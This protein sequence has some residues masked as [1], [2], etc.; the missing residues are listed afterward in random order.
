MADGDIFNIF[1]LHI[2][3]TCRSCAANWEFSLHATKWINIAISPR[4]DCNVWDNSTRITT[5]NRRRVGVDGEVNWKSKLMRICECR[6]SLM[7]QTSST[8][9]I[10][11]RSLW[12]RFPFPP[13]HK[14]RRLQDI[15]NKT[16]SNLSSSKLWHWKQRREGLNRKEKEENVEGKPKEKKT[17]RQNLRQTNFSFTLKKREKIVSFFLVYA[18]NSEALCAVLKNMYLENKVYEQRRRLSLKEASNNRTQSSER[19]K[20]SA[21]IRSIKVV[22]PEGIHNKVETW[23]FSVPQFLSSFQQASLSQCV[24][25]VRIVNVP[26]R[27]SALHIFSHFSLWSFFL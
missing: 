23:C 26:L 24:H 18:D 2:H 22:S 11:I 7:W 5:H 4:C 15:A 1:S 17:P 8:S 27:C 10:C 12:S 6:V 13:Q 9:S 19:E 3:I 14:G 25:F 21:L 16:C 20:V